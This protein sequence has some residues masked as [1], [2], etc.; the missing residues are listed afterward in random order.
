MLHYTGGGTESTFVDDNTDCRVVFH[1]FLQGAL[2]EFERL[3]MFEHV[4]NELYYIT[5][6]YILDVEG[7][8]YSVHSG[9]CCRHGTLACNSKL[10]APAGDSRPQ[11]PK[12]VGSLCPARAKTPSPVPTSP[13]CGLFGHHASAFDSGVGQTRE[14]DPPLFSLLGLGL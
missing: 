8:G 3:N 13:P 4:F 2:N 12:G 10:L 14:V 1:V 11:R 7:C 6:L 5:T 9:C